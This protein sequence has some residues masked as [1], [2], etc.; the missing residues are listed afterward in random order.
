MPKNNWTPAT[1]IRHLY[2]SLILRMLISIALWG[3][4]LYLVAPAFQCGKFTLST[5]WGYALAIPP[6]LLI[7]FIMSWKL[8]DNA[9]FG[10]AFVVISAMIASAVVFFLGA[11][12]SN[13]LRPFPD[14][15][16]LSIIGG[17]VLI[18]ASAVV[19]NYILVDS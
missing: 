19:A 7:G 17:L 18:I 9:G 13:Q 4:L 10:G 5:R 8:V 12:I 2:I 1:G 15:D 16:R 11:Y 3:G 6:G 14:I